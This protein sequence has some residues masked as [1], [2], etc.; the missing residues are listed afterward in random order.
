M[1]KSKKFLMVFLLAIAVFV[2]CGQSNKVEAR[3]VWVYTEYDSHGRKIDYYVMT[4]TICRT[5]KDYGNGI[6]V[7]SKMIYNS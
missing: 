5:K 4:E 2:V 6:L 7:T 1:E 3:D